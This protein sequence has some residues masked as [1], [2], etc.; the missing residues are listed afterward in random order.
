METE[1]AAPPLLMRSCIRHNR[2]ND[3]IHMYRQMCI[4]SCGRGCDLLRVP[5]TPCVHQRSRVHAT[6]LRAYAK[7]QLDCRFTV[8]RTTGTGTGTLYV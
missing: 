2:Q 8:P 1:T 7:L 5:P 3:G 6:R 4:G